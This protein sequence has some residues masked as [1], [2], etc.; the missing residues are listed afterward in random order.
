MGRSTLKNILGRIEQKKADYA[1]YA[2]TDTENAAL[3]TF[4]D[5]AQ[6]FENFWDLYTLCVAVPKGFFGLQAA[7][8]V[9][10]FKGSGM[11][12]VA[13][14]EA[15]EVDLRG[16]IPPGLRPAKRPY[17]AEGER[18]VLTIR[19]NRTL[20][21]QLPFEPEGDVLG[22]LV[23][24]PARGVDEH[25]ELFF[26]KFANRIGF[27]IHNRFV[28]EKNVEH[29]RF[30]RNLVAD[31]EH[32]VIAPNMVYKLY[33]RDIKARMAQADKAAGALAAGGDTAAALE[34]LDDAHEGLR[35][36]IENIENHHRNMSLFLETLFRRGHFDEGHLVL[37]K[38]QCDMLAEVIRPQLEHYEDKFRAMDIRVEYRGHGGPGQGLQAVDVGLMAQ[39]YA[40][41]FSNAVKYTAEPIGLQGTRQKLMAYGLQ[42]EPDFPAP[43]QEGVRC[44]MFTT[45]PALRPQECERVFEEGYRGSAVRGTPG[46]GHGLSF[47]K[48]VVQMHGGVVGCEPGPDG[49]TFYF[50][51]PQGPQTPP[52]PVS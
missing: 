19:G 17:Y 30:I 47:V 29:L 39:V 3:K 42:V 44:F 49:N 10:D 28:L 32:N 5:L 24:Q 25:K 27:N 34:E 38:R 45:G 16:P 18:L 43:G 41:L 7:L 2:L 21:D 11:F 13:G 31:I 14:T 12:L 20:I 35:A 22:M 9:L 40:N 52:A 23:L 51:L 48:N 15:A 6:E 46:T 1:H 37:R 36:E 33:L 50:I 26:E 8:Y 4:Y